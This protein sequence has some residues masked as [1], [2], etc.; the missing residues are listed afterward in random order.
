MRVATLVLNWNG[1]AHLRTCLA[2]LVAQDHPDHRIVVVDNGSHDG[3]QFWLRGAYPEIELVETFRNTGFA[4]GNNI[5]IRS[6]LADPEV[7]YLAL[8]N[9]D[10]R[11]PGNWVSTLVGALEAGPEFSAA[12]TALVFEHD[13]S[14]INSLGIAVE[15]SLWAFDDCCMQTDP[16]RF[17]RSEVFGVTAGACMYRREMVEALLTDDCFFDP[18]FFAYY[19]DVDVAFRG[20]H[21]GFRSL[22]VPG[23]VVRHVGSA[24]SNK[25][26]HR[27]VYLLE[28]N[29]WYYVIRNVPRAELVA[30]GP[31]FIRKRVERVRQWVKPLQP[32]ILVWSVLGNLIWILKLPRLL[33]ARRSILGSARPGELARSLNIRISESD[34][35]PV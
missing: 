31:H 11:V 28:R 23:P 17:A 16:S 33:R 30:R 26:V 6:I 18:S 22:F 8:V 13:P 21:Q 1:K 5:G 27:K 24:T 7:K 9:N 12:Q 2:D 35:A 14:I 15:P 25:S 32:R 19:E 3:S 4:E 29:H 34:H 10:T 20:R